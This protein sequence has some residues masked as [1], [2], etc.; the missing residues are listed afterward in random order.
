MGLVSQK[1]K[2][3][4]SGD[5]TLCYLRE[6]MEIEKQ[7]KDRELKIAEQRESNMQKLLEQQQ[8]QNQTMLALLMSQQNRSENQK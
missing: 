5:D 4:R 3:R 8:Q 6:K 7:F 2:K 1:K